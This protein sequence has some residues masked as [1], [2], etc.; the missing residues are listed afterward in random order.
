M[1]IKY[2]L[3]VVYLTDCVLCRPRRSLAA[4]RRP[5]QRRRA[6]F[7][8]RLAQRP[9]SEAA[10]TATGGAVC[11]WYY[12]VFVCTASFVFLERRKSTPFSSK[13]CVFKPSMPSKARTQLSPIYFG[14]I[15]SPLS[16]TSHPTLSP[17]YILLSAFVYMPAFFVAFSNSLFL[18]FPR[19]ETW[20]ATRFD[21][22][23]PFCLCSS[24]FSQSRFLPHHRVYICFAP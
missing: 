4:R 1:D 3:Y 14:S 8:R 9:Q 22:F 12:V 18:C 11:H 19:G 2:R 21:G 5:R 24:S 20:F 6:F 10:A 13:Q 7:R 15:F 16:G 23:P 17:S